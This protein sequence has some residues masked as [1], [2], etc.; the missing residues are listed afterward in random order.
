MTVLGVLARAP[1]PGLVADGLSSSALPRPLD[2]A[3]A[4]LPE[5]IRPG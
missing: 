5:A 4:Q 1:G 3:R 2:E